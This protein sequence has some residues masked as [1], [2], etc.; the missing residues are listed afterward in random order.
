MIKYTYVGN[1]CMAFLLQDIGDK[2]GELQMG[3]WLSLFMAVFQA[4]E[5]MCM[6]ITGWLESFL[7]K[8]DVWLFHV[9]QFEVQF[10][11]KQ[12][13]STQRIIQILTQM[14]K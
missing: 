3:A 1:N 4:M 5:K 10:L 8:Q 11:Q 9:V 7:L 14:L 6:S 13:L 12:M 2:I